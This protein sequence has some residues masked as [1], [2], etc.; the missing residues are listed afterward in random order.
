MAQMPINCF[1]GNLF[2]IGI[3]TMDTVSMAASLLGASQEYTQQKVGIAVM[4]SAIE[5]QNQVVDLLAS[6]ADQPLM[7]SGSVGTKINSVA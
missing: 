7:T 2:T 1:Q 4:K 6:V 3:Q 5:A